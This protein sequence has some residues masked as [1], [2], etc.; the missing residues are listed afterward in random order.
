MSAVSRATVST[1][2]MSFEEMF[3]EELLKRQHAGEIEEESA[4]R[5][6]TAAERIVE[7]LRPLCGEVPDV[8]LDA[9]TFEPLDKA[10]VLACSHSFNWST[11]KQAVD[12]VGGMQEVRKLSGLPCPTCR[13][14]FSPSSQMIACAS[15]RHMTEHFKK[16][17]EVFKKNDGK[18]SNC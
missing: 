15:S 17:E 14:K 8:A 7:E 13:W 18:S 10:M 4:K 11:I 16:I 9:V 6:R 2:T 3:Q 12:S 5:Q 1:Q